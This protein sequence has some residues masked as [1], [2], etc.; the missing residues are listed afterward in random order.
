MSRLI[1][2]N[3]KVYAL[4]KVAFEI[5]SGCFATCFEIGEVILIYTKVL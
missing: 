2:F 1:F 4:L 5:G 3:N